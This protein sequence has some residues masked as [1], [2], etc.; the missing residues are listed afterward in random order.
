VMVVVGVRTA[1][2]AA[3]RGSAPPGVDPLVFLAVPL[4]DMLCFA[5]FVT[6]AVW[7][8]ARKEAHKRLMLLAYASIITAA[9]GRIAGAS[10]GPLL[11]LGLSLTFVLAGVIYDVAS[12]GRV[13][14]AYVWGGTLL[15]VSL[16]LRLAISGTAAWRA[17]A[18]SLVR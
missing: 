6:A 17:F 14:P 3:A 12:R 16:P 5:G 7:L 10:L 1:V 13:H 15:A 2:T 18:D 9:V 11:A 8:R 4:F